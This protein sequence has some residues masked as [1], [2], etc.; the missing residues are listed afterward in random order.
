MFSGN[1]E[2]P[3]AWNGLN[4][5]DDSWYS[6]DDSHVLSIMQQSAVTQTE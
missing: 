5:K 2:R 6:T 3:A 4:P 1:I